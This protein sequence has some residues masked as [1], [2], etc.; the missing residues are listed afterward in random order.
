MRRHTWHLVVWSAV[1]LIALVAIPR[2]SAQTG[3]V[4]CESRGN[5]RQQCAVERE[6]RVELARQLSEAPCREQANWGAG[7]GF[8]WVSGGCRADFL[9][10]ATRAS[11]GNGA[12]TPM[13]L[14]ACQSEADRRLPGYTYQQIRTEAISSQGNTSWVRWSAGSTGGRCL[15]EANGR[16]LEFTTDG[17]GGGVGG[18]KVPAATTRITCESRGSGRQECPLPDGAQ[19]RLVRQLSQSPCRLN[20]TY[21][22]GAGYVWVAEGCRGEFEVSRPEIAPGYGGPPA[23][24]AT[25]LTCGSAGND[26]R[27]CAIPA[28]ST[29]RLVM[30]RSEAPC[31]LNRSYGIESSYVWAS[32]GCRAM[33]EVTR[34]GISGGTGETVRR[35]TCE[36]QGTV[37]QQCGAPGATQIRLA[38]RLSTS[39]CTLDQTYG[40]GAGYIWVGNGCRGEFDVTLAATQGDGSG[41]PGSPGLAERVTCQSSGGERAECRI[42]SGGQVQ[43]V[44]QLSTAPCTRN[45]TWGTEYGVLWVTKGCRGEFEVR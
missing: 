41:L 2:A 44:R 8:I 34:G 18:G 15:V 39:P 11:Q 25:R 4:R 14:R 26:R 9:V 19:I 5:D 10:T 27:E 31:R 13:Q 37:R 12:A 21:G 43:L 16:V 20:D 7:P 28:G 45:S 24:G 35:I 32:N 1:A 42:R 3:T 30:Q 40:I 22:K 29:A 17:A 23:G 36:S 38:R 6:A 33:F